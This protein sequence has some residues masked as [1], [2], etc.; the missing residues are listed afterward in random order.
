MAVCTVMSTDIEKVW[1]LSFKKALKN[2]LY[3]LGS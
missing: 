2:T 3:I 1:I